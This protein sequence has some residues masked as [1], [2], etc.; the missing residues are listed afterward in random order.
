M[1]AAPL[2]ALTGAAPAGNRGALGWCA[3]SAAT[4]PRRRPSGMAGRRRRECGAQGG[5]E[6]DPSRQRATGPGTDHVQTLLTQGSS[7][8]D[9]H[10]HHRYPLVSRFLQSVRPP[11]KTNCAKPS[12]PVHIAP[13]GAA[14]ARP[15]HSLNRSL[16]RSTQC[17][18]ARWR[19]Q[20]EHARA[21][22]VVPGRKGPD[23]QN[24]SQAFGARR[25]AAQGRQV[26]AGGGGRRRGRQWTIGRRLRSRVA[27]P[28]SESQDERRADNRARARRP[29][30]ARARAAAGSATGPTRD[31]VR[32][33]VIT[34]G[35]P[36]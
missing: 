29:L 4:R 11:A 35:V 27:R 19:V 32:R 12:E 34:D 23:E 7:L 17:R 6:R 5:A 9:P 8:P 14:H 20:G 33:I 1:S 16:R 24:Q 36:D 3:L 2:P 18:R 13:A 28:A 25:R 26:D 30:G 15:E 31:R 21:M 10:P 22:G